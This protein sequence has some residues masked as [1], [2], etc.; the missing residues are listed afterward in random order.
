MEA[1]NGKI[2]GEVM[3]TYEEYVSRAA[4]D[5][6]LEEISEREFYKEEDEVCGL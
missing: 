3:E 4:H 5:E 2:E 1:S 6:T